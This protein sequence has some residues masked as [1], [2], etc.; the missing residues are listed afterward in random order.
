MHFEIFHGADGWYWRCKAANGKITAIG[1]EPF[2]TS[3]SA[4]RACR[5]HML[6]CEAMLTQ[7]PAKKLPIRAVAQ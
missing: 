5:R 3:S 7:S 4:R 6:A 1:G 2:A